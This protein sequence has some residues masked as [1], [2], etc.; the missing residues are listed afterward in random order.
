MWPKVR[1][2]SLCVRRYSDDD[3]MSHLITHLS[4]SYCNAT[5]ESIHFFLL[6]APF[7]SG[8][9]ISQLNIFEVKC[10]SVIALREEERPVTLL[11]L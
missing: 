7:S 4:G 6:L 2:W 1:R 3:I 8:E 5:M 10:T 11:L 9:N